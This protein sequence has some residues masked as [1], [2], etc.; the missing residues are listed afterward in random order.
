[1]QF[2]RHNDSPALDDFWTRVERDWHRASSDRS[3]AVAPSD[4]PASSSANP[5]AAPSADDLAATDPATLET[6]SGPTP[7]ALPG[8]EVETLPEAAPE[9][10]SGTTSETTADAAIAS[11]A[12]TSTAGA[13]TAAAAVAPVLS[14]VDAAALLTGTGSAAVSGTATLTRHDGTIQAQSGDVIENLDIYADGVGIELE[15]DADVTIRNVRIHYNGTDQ[16]GYGIDAVG[17][18]NLTIDGVELINAGAPASGPNS[19]PEQYGIGLFESPGAS[20]SHVTV[21]DA[22]TG[23]YLQDSPNATLQGIEGYNMRGPFPRGQLVQLNRSDNSSLTDFYSYNDLETSW[24]EDNVNIGSSN[25]TVAN[26]LIDGNN[27]PSGVGVIIEG[28]TGVHVSNVDTVRM[29]NGAFS[30]YGSGNTFDD[31]RAFDNFADSHAG[32]GTPMSGSLIFSLA[33]DS[34]ITNAAYQNPAAPG[35][36][37]YGGGIQDEAFGGTFQASEITGEAPMAAYHNTFSWS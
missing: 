21:R 27:S 32:R 30:D 31:V 20:V 13:E 2:T 25:V 19:D 24:T 10:T 35:N 29:G 28:G 9:V 17:A 37:V 36:V 12:S 34:T 15:D 14:D 5:S 18:Q 23:L 3:N 11:P 1:M 6:A 33:D 7:A 8:S 16:G 22:S 26:G 4:V